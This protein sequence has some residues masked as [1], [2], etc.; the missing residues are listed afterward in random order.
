M[1]T[2]LL[3]LSRLQREIQGALASSF[4][5]ATSADDWTQGA[6]VL[7]LSIVFGL[8]HAV[9]PGHGKSILMA[10]FMAGDARVRQAFTSSLKLIATHV[11]SAV[12]LVLAALTIVDISFGF[13]PADFP[14][15]RQISYGGVALVGLFLLIQALR[16]HPARAH[17][18]GG[19]F[20]PYLAGLSPCPLTTIIMVAASGTG[21][22]AFGVLVSI[23]MALGMVATV[24]AFA[25]LAILGRRW[26]IAASSR[27]MSTIMRV[28]RVLQ[29][30]GAGCVMALGSFLL[31]AEVT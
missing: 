11:G 14:L 6:L 29:V 16:P 19:R 28:G 7:L 31:L 3:E 10:Y 27:H 5:E 1:D 9:G 23:A 2:V 20:L 17:V 13:R 24:G 12:V 25:L 22:V 4:R 30:L 15:V 8:V 21:A 26:L 18:H